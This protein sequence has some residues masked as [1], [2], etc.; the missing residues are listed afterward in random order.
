MPLEKITERILEDARES[1]AKIQEKGKDDAE[2]IMAHYEKKVK[3]YKEKA[4]REAQV[5]AKEKQSQM[6]NT[7]KRLARND[8]LAHKQDWIDRVFKEVKA[9]ILEM[10]E[11]DYISFLANL[12]KKSNPEGSEEIGLSRKDRVLWGKL[13]SK[14]GEDFPGHHFKLMESPFPME[15]GIFIKR[16]QMFLNASLDAILGELRE[17][18]GKEVVQHLFP[19][20]ESGDGV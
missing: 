12:V 20:E 2:K 9:D 11:P 16:G 13:S 15:A 8:I 5:R 1:A 4:V 19:E 6:I 17:K 14:L 3:D 7:A 18:E 10:P